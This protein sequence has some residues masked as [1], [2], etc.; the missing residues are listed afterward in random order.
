MDISL[1][2]LK[3]TSLIIL[4]R[5][6]VVIYALIV[7]GSLGFAV[8]SLN[9]I[10]GTSAE[11]DGYVSSTNNTQFDTRTIQR[12]N[13]LK[14]REQNNGSIDLSGGRSNPFVE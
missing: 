13:E 6:H 12:I 1:S 2:Q 3:S 10:V 8:L 11:S 14:S 4:R 7:A 9:N 5:Y